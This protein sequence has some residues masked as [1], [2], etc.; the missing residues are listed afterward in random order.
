MG[1]TVGDYK[2]IHLEDQ[3]VTGYLLKD[4]GADGHLRSLVFYYDAW[5]SAT[6]I[7]NGI[8]AAA[9]AVQGDGLLIGNMG[10]R[11]AFIM[12]KI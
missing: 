8:T 1:E 3:V 2:P 11:K 4:L 10:E 12:D 7:N 9:H 6:V 5:G